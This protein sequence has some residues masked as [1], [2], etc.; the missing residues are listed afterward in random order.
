MCVYSVYVVCAYDIRGEEH[1]RSKSNNVYRP[2]VSPPTA[3]TGTGCPA[4]EAK[5]TFPTRARTGP[6][7]RISWRNDEAAAAATKYHLNK[8]KKKKE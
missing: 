2:T 3:V 6:P 8:K 7:H 5:P 4:T 1:C